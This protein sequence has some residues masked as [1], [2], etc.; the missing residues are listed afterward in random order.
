M[1]RPAS[2]QFVE[3]QPVHGDEAG[4]GDAHPAERVALVGIEAGGEDDQLRGERPYLRHNEAFGCGQVLGI[5]AAGGQRH[6]QGVTLARADTALACRPG[7]GIERIL[8]NGQVVHRGAAIEDVLGAVA[9]V[10][11]GIEDQHA[12]ERR[13]GAAGL[14][15]RLAG[16]RRGAGSGSAIP[17][18][19]GA[20]RCISGSGCTPAGGSGTGGRRATRRRVSPGSGRSTGSGSGF[21]NGRRQRAGQRRGG[22]N[23]NVVE[24][25]E[26]HGAVAFRVMAGRAYRA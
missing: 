22:G 20:G 9:V 2:V 25:A 18:G 16:H 13:Q 7:A 6:V 10:Y 4:G 17:G 1:R 14:W 5:P 12:L 11:V 19:Y 24:Q 15:L 8:M 23:R 21:G 3:Q 26:A